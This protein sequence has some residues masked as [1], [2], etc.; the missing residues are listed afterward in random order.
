MAAHGATG[1]VTPLANAF[2]RERF[3]YV[4]ESVTLAMRLLDGQWRIVNFLYPDNAPCYQ[5]LSEG[6]ARYAGSS[7]ANRRDRACP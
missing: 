6:L 4:R 2:S 3:E 1:S 7:I 5:D